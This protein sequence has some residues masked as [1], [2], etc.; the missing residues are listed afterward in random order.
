MSIDKDLLLEI[1]SGEITE[2]RIEL[3][4]DGSSKV[5]EGR[6]AKVF[7]FGALMGMKIIRDEAKIKDMNTSADR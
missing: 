4:V 3:G 7:A 6:E 5:F 2:P 1:A